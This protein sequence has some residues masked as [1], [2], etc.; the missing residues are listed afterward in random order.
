MA[1]QSPVPL[2]HAFIV[3][4]RV[5]RNHKTGRYDLIG[6]HLGFVVPDFPCTVGVAIYAQV[7]SVRGEFYPEF[8][9][10]GP[11]GKIAWET[12]FPEPM[13]TVDGDPLRQIQLFAH[14]LPLPFSRPG[15][16]DLL[17]LAAGEEIAR[18]PLKIDRTSPTGG[19]NN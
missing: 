1:R 10:W 18:Y 5:E 11:D 6:T 14:N 19:A 17:L 15:Q 2:V 13:R 12:R 7:S 4:D 9:L 3:C 8:R 16:Y